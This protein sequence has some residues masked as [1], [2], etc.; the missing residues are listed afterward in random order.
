MKLFPSSTGMDINPVRM[1][2]AEGV[3]LFQL[4]RHINNHT[5]AQQ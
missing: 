4:L 3:Q 2:H 1:Q 5:L